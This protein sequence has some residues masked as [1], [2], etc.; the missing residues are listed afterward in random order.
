MDPKTNK[1]LDESSKKMARDSLKSFYTKPTRQQNSSRTSC[2]SIISNQ[3]NSQSEDQVMLD[4]EDEELT[5]PFDNF[6]NKLDDQSRNSGQKIKRILSIAQ[7]LAVY[8]AK[9]THF[10]NLDFKDIWNSS[11]I[12]KELPMLYKEAIRA[13][14]ICA[15]SS[16]S[17]SC[18]SIAGYQERHARSNLHAKTLRF[19]MLSKQTDKIEEI[20]NNFDK[21][22]VK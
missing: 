20:L 6:C 11:D 4:I 2:S 22:Q 19:E 13:N 21:K 9:I 8:D 3:L 15:S 17:E 12:K 7:E 1:H 18:F 5:D 14:T 10:P 16:P